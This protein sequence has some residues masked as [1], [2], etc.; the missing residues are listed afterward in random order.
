M[1]LDRLSEYT[2]TTK[3]G[4]DAYH[5]IE[6]AKKIGF[7]AKG[8]K[9]DFDYIQKNIKSPFIAHVT[10]KNHCQHYVAVYKIKNNRLKIMDPAL[11]LIVL[12]KDEFLSIWNGV[13]LLLYPVVCLPIIKS[14]NTLTSFI[15][16]LIKPFKKELIY[17]FFISTIITI[18]SII[19]TYYFEYI[20]DAINKKSNLYIVSFIFLFSILIKIFSEYYRTKIII[21]MNKKIDQTL[22]L[23]TYSH[24]LSL[25]YK[26]YKNKTTGDIITRINDLNYIKE[27]IADGSVTIFIDTVLIIFTSIFLYIINLKLFTIS[28]LI[29]VIYAIVVI[30]FNK[31]LFKRLE[32]NFS[33]QSDVNSYLIESINSYETIKGINIRNQIYDRF[34]THFHKLI[35]STNKINRISNIEQ[36]LKNSIDYIGGFL[37]LFIGAILVIKNTITIGELITYNAIYMYFLEPLKNIVNFGLIIKKSYISLKRLNEL[38]DI[39]GEVMIKH[40]NKD[41]V[42]KGDIFINNLNYSY[43]EVSFILKNLN[44]KID[45]GDKIIILGSSGCGKSTL[46]G[47]IL[48]NYSC[49]R[50]SIFID[51]IDIN[52]YNLSD[53]R[54][55]IS[56][57]SQQELLYNDTLYNN[58]DLYRNN[59]TSKV[60]D[61]CEIVC[62][63]DLLT[64]NPFGLDMLIEENGFNLSGGERQ[65]I[66][67]ARTLLKNSKILILDE[68]TSQ[69]D[70]NL[71]RKILENIM[72]I[73]KEKTVIFISH[74]D[75]N[76]DLFNKVIDFE[77]RNVKIE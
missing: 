7:N 57:V 61:V 38:Y 75:N 59:G 42:F 39:D 8:L 69:I 3:G 50:N 72:D 65:R 12:K 76:K 45:I 35:T 43:D 64:K 16:N 73:Y 47:L 55:N 10:L 24:I 19:G 62:I 37:I 68:S 29:A 22:T 54:N 28:I 1:S 30:I 53:I 70:I 14:K 36:I 4:T 13:V 33:Y 44:M 56:Y 25:P 77:E 26:Y 20:I 52:D 40:E 18:T 49:P 17:M 46:M 15:Y 60:T 63:Q 71:E 67:L 5:L 9:C 21:Y 31:I 66:V 48:K 27:L 23:E 58:I 32:E 41:Y 74:R 6:G 11:G 34:K 51:K 2:M